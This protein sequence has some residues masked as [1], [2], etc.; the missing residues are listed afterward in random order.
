[1]RPGINWMLERGTERL[2]SYLMSFVIRFFDNDRVLQSSLVVSEC[3][4]INYFVVVY[5]F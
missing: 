3:E 2:Y 1:M 5:F 4:C